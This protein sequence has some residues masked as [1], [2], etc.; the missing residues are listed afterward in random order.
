MNAPMAAEGGYTPFLKLLHWLVVVLLVVQ[1]AIA[2]N[3]PDIGPKTVP[4]TIINLHFSVGALILGV[5]VIRLAWR[6]THPEPMPVAGLPPWQVISARAVHYLL[7]I[8]LFAIPIL[9]WVNAS[10]RGFELSFFG[11]I[12]L[13]QIVPTRSSGFSWTGDVHIIAAYYVLLPLIGLHILAA[14]YH[15][16]IR[17]DGVLERMLPG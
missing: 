1:Y 3:M 9:G 12:T 10:F 17:K 4:N 6:L 2:W 7:Y 8:L 15:W 13:P 5:L 14:L 16:L 11:V